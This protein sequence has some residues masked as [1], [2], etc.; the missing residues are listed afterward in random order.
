MPTPG[1]RTADCVFCAIVR[2]DAPAT[3]LHRDELVVAF[4][5][6]RPV[7]PGHLLVVPRA[8]AKLIPELDGRILARLW[9]VATDLN[10]ALRASTLTVEAV[11]VHVADGHA[12]GQEVAHVHIHL[13]PRRDYDG[14][15][16]RFPPG[17]GTEPGRPA[18][19][20]IASQIRPGISESNAPETSGH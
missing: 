20:T 15:G 11:S 17:Y 14:F 4:M 9:L 5:D 10:R 8:H 13:I 1:A 16:F 19:E 2:G 12:A 18:L 7:Q 6:I 3:F